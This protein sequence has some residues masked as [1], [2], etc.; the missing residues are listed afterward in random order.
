MTTE[1]ERPLGLGLSEGLGPNGATVRALREG[2]LIAVYM[3]HDRHADKTQAPADYL[4]AFGSAVSKETAKVSA[5]QATALHAENQ[6][7]RQAAHD[8]CE[9][10][11]GLRRVLEIATTGK[12][13]KRKAVPVSGSARRHDGACT[14]RHCRCDGTARE[15]C[16]GCEE[17]PRERLRGFGA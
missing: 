9:M 8:A 14:P 6:R 13:G 2:E 12:S 3:T 11:A 4:L 17:W 5:A 10:L 1:T 7:L 16:Q 15:D